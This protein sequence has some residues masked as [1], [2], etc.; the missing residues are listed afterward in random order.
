MP[1]GDP[2]F[3][4][5]M[6]LAHRPQPDQQL[7]IGLARSSTTFAAERGRIY[8][9][10][11]GETAVLLALILLVSFLSENARLG[12]G[13]VKTALVVLTFFDLWA[14]GRHRLLDVAPLRPLVEQSPVLARLGAEPR[15]TRVANGSLRNLPMLAGLAPIS[16]YR[17]LDLPAVGSLTATAQGPLSQPRFRSEVKAALRASG[18]GLRV[19]DPIENQFD[20]AWKRAPISG[21]SIEDPA[22][23]SWLFGAAWLGQQ[24]ALAP[25]F[26]IW[27]ALEPPA[28]AWLVLVGEVADP[29]VLDVWSGD[30]RE[31][32][33][34]LRTATPLP[35]D[36]PRPEEW[37]ISVSA[38]G[39]SWVII[40]QLADPQWT[41]RW[42]KEGDGRIGE[43][44]ILPTFR[45]QGEPGG[46]QR[47]RVP[48]AGRW[49]LR[50]EYQS[51]DVALGTA[52]STIAWASWLLAAVRAGYPRREVQP[53]SGR[54]QTEA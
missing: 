13:T 35:C 18:T 39:P 32:L 31:I 5:V 14:L 34:I 19:F 33:N 17:T 50:L 25:T 54:D 1:W 16:A 12:A 11:L 51:R 48:G 21:E 52:L 29:E 37:T 23:A 28:R 49:T 7:P 8:A 22:L 10:E 3:R 6:E 4:S 26:L 53:V 42:F 38:D 30:H 15:G 47:V 27:R 2:G 9:A 45:K 44:E 36:S 20:Q 41:A 43:E 46:W 24:P 40:S